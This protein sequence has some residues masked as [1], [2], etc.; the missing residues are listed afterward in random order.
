LDLANWLVG[1]PRT[2][3]A[4]GGKLT[5]LEHDVEDFVDLTASAFDVQE[6][7]TLVHVHL[8]FWQR[9]PQRHFSLITERAAVYFDYVSAI[10]RVQL[11]DGPEEPLRLDPF[12]RN[13]MFLAELRHFAECLQTRETPAPG[14]TDGL[15]ALE[16]AA[17]AH[18]A[19]VDHRAVMLS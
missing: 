16:F 18:R 3:S 5:D 14:L 13:E 11:C 6:R 17:A 12:V 7:E 4:R 8:N 1:L 10:L 19:L 9:P 15:R 2:V